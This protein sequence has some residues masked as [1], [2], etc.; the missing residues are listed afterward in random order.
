MALIVG[1]LSAV[2]AEHLVR[3]LAEHER[4]CRTNRVEVPGELRDL[5][6]ALSARD[7]QGRPPLGDGNAGG[8]HE[9]ML[10]ALDYAAAGTRL[11]VS[12]RT[13]RR[14]VADGRL[15]AVS[16]SGCRRI[17][18]ADLADYVESLEG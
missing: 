13:V 6:K 3:A 10:L 9:S 4:W 5:L 16:I 17:R 2:M 14:I 12:E 15:P 1:E 18:V 11:G 8:D 7:G